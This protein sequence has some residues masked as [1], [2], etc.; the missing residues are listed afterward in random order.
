MAKGS[1]T[2]DDA[3]LVHE[4]A[5]HMQPMLRDRDATKQCETAKTVERIA[6]CCIAEARQNARAERARQ[7]FSSDYQTEVRE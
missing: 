1:I 5:I 7:P 2:L 4:F 3:R 6:Y